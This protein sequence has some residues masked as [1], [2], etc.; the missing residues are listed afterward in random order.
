MTAA[1]LGE[2]ET[3]V[4]ALL[5]PTSKNVFLP[6]ATTRNP[7]S[8]PVYLPANGELLAAVALMA[9]GWDGD[10]GRPTSGS[11]ADGTWTVRYEGLSR[12]P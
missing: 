1:R 5:M 11:Q 4:A 2:P 8:L 7:P 3:A 12:S 10:G 6:M 9:D